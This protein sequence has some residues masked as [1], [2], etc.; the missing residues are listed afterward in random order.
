MEY[1]LGIELAPQA[2]QFPQIRLGGRG[3]ESLRFNADGKCS[4][5]MSNLTSRSTK[6]LRAGS[7]MPN[8]ITGMGK[9]GR[10]FDAGAGALSPINIK[11]DIQNNSGHS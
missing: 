2:N 10:Q 11:F 7:A 5:A 6:T 8:W 9:L 4:N 1:G 3:W